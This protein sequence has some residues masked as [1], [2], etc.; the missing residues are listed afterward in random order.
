[1][2]GRYTVTAGAEI[3]KKRFEVGEIQGELRL[4]RYNAAPNQLNPV[5][6]SHSGKRVLT[7]YQW[8]LIP[9]W[10]RDPAIG[11]KMINARAESILEKVSFKRLLKSNR[12]LVVADG[13]YEWKKEGNEKIPHRIVLNSNDLFGFAGLW[14][15]WRSPN[16]TDIPTFTIITTSAENHSVLQPLHNRMP[17]ILNKVHEQ[18]WLEGDFETGE[19]VQKVL[20]QYPSD[21]MNSYP[22]SKVVNSPQFDVSGCIDRLW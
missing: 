10:S 9:S 7:Q 5:I 14:D 1:M 15:K 3:I 20:I 13:F 2:C 17:V 11:N 19:L 16:G 22:V 12:C 21:E 18:L 8:G 4:P 6:L